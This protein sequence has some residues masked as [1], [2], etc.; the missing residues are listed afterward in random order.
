M[1]FIVGLLPSLYRGVISNSVL[2]VV[3]RYSKIVCF[4][5]CIQ[6]IDASELATVMVN[7]VF[8]KF[9]TLSSIVIDRGL[10]FISIYWVSFY[11]YLRVK[12]KLSIAFYPQTDGQTERLN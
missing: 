6:T 7:E 5:P 11:Y 4:I 9:E 12:R 1:D 10:L 3:N 2:V 8:S